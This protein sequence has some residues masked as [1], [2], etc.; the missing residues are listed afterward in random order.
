[1]IRKQEENFSFNSIK[2]SQFWA[3]ALNA[4]NLNADGDSRRNNTDVISFWNSL[5]DHL[6]HLSKQ[7]R[8]QKRIERILE[9][10]NRNKIKLSEMSVLDVG[11]GVGDFTLA[12]ASC[13]AAVMALE[14]APAMLEVLKKRIIPGSDHNINFIQEKWED[15][16]P[17][18]DS[19]TDSFDLV[20]ASLNPGVR[21]TAALNKMIAVSRNWCVLCDIAA[22]GRRSPTREELWEKI[23]GEKMPQ[24][25]YNIIFPLNYLYA[26]GYEV[27][28]QTWMEE[29]GEKLPVEKVAANLKNYF[30][31]Y[32]EP[33]TRITD[34]IDSYLSE[35]AVNGIYSESYPVHMG[36]IFWEI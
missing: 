7:E 29:W 2:K 22:G 20:F 4:A 12:F 17:V 15:I 19:L 28:F 11:A 18:K 30:S 23:F 27:C 33:T 36:M 16:D 1:M 14:P 3:N 26:C 6:K 9:Q 34:Q 35:R 21:D 13:G 24:T 5:A 32:T 31:L 25:D 8:V 10:I